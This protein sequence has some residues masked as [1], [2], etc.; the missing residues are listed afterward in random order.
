MSVKAAGAELQAAAAPPAAA[1]AAL[2]PDLLR[3][4]RVPSPRRRLLADCTSGSAASFLS[5]YPPLLSYDL[6]KVVALLPQRKPLVAPPHA[7]SAMPKVA[8]YSEDNA[9]PLEMHKVSSGWCAGGR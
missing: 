2:S 3:F 9:V 5:H 7:T 6:A 8:V 4:C 1:A